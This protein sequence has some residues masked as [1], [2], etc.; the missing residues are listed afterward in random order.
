M[1]SPKGITARELTEGLIN[2]PEVPLHVRQEITNRIKRNRELARPITKD[3]RSVGIEMDFDELVNDRFTN[4]PE[5]IPILLKHFNRDYPENFKDAIAGWFASIKARIPE[6]SR[7]LIDEFRCLPSKLVPHSEFMSGRK[8][9]IANNI[10]EVAVEEH[11]PEI[12]RLLKDNRH[13]HDRYGL[14]FAVGRF[15]KSHAE[16]LAVLKEFAKDKETNL[17]K[18]ARRALKGHG[19]FPGGKI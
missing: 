15:R 10:A 1:V 11:L 13:G 16:A 4:Y 8:F 12:I 14:I 7:I 2:S 5:A 19:L 6:V 9:Q 3:L 18:A 17:G